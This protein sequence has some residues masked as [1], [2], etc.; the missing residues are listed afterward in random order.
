MPTETI[1]TLRVPLVPQP[2]GAVRYDGTGIELNDIDGDGTH[3]H[4]FE[5]L[6]DDG[7]PTERYF[8]V[9]AC[10]VAAFGPVSIEQSSAGVWEWLIG[11]MPDDARQS[12]AYIVGQCAGNAEFVAQFNRLMGCNL[13]QSASRAPINKMIDDACGASGE[14]LDDMGRFCAFVYETIWLRLPIGE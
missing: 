11:Q 12:F 3:E 10:P 5:R 14:S 1:Q 13:G 9:G 4:Y 8:S 2:S 7:T 6:N